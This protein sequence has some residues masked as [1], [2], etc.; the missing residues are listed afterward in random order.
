MQI[1][2][3]QLWVYPGMQQYHFI[4]EASTVLESLVYTSLSPR[5]MDR[6]VSISLSHSHYRLY[7][8][9]KIL[10]AILDMPRS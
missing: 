2:I 4:T 3:L 6:A 9:G 7:I 1:L 8:Q 5:L 10:T